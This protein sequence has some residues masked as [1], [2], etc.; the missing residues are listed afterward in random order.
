[1]MGKLFVLLRRLVR[2]HQFPKHSYI[3]C[4]C[5][6]VHACSYC[7]GPY[8]RHSKWECPDVDEHLAEIANE[9]DYWEEEYQNYLADRQREYDDMI[10]AGIGWYEDEE[11][12]KQKR[13]EDIDRYEDLLGEEPF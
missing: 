9:G 11:D 2:L 13:Q 7:G 1:M 8:N 4:W 10:M 5:G 3:E 6:I 12:K